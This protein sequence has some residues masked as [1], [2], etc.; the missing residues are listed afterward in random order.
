MASLTSV[1]IGA[2]RI[3]RYGVYLLVFGLIAR[4][5]FNIGHAI[6]L[7]I[8]PP[9][10]PEATVTF[11]K[12]PVL[13]FPEKTSPEGLSFKVE[14]ADGKLPEF[15]I[16]L[17]VYSMPPIPQNIYALED[18]KKI[19][20]ALGFDSSNGKP[21]LESTPNVYLFTKR[22]VPSQLTM[23]IVTGVFSISYDIKQDP[24]ILSGVP[25]SEDAAGDQIINYMRSGGILT[26]DI[27]KG[28][29][30]YQYLKA[31]EN[32]FTPEASL[33]EANLI[34]V[35]L[36]RKNFGPKDGYISVTPK[37]PEA[38]V[39][40]L[41]GSG[42]KQIVAAEYHYY[43]VDE[44]KSGTYPIKTAEEALDDLKNQKGFIVNRPDSSK[45]ITIR[46]IYLAYYDAGQYAEY[47]QP[48]VVFEGDN[49]F[50]AYV[51]VVQN[52]YYGAEATKSESTK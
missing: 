15:P 28:R 6:W 14:T 19:A 27:E 21:L 29:R 49:N 48:V 12:L 16:Q 13:P 31:D 26:P 22:G 33:S 46:K 20:S 45:D 42:T 7:Q 18:A 37:M 5:L 30:T 17:P 39:W 25:L 8:F 40:F 43:P 34:K 47:Y 41:I 52:D 2:R 3:I 32:S 24:S 11:G 35:N 50:L 38:N 9:P 44:S 1:S 36:F 23:N 10:P 51:P 4:T